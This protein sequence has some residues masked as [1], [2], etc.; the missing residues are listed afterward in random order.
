MRILWEKPGTWECWACDG[1]HFKVI[2]ISKDWIDYECLTCHQ[3][4]AMLRD[5]FIKFIEAEMDVEEDE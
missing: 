5:D 1:R 4:D 2:K 3:K